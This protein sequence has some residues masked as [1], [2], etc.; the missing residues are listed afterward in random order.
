MSASKRRISTRAFLVAFSLALL[1][2]IVG[3]AAMALVYYASTERARSEAEAA[4]TAR[5]YSTILDG[6]VRTLMSVLNGLAKSSLLRRKE[7]SDFHE[8]ARRTVQGGDEVIVLRRFDTEQILNTGVPFG[9]HLPPAISLIPEEIEAYKSG[10]LRVSNVYASPLG[11][12]PRIAVAMKPEIPGPDD[13]LL[14]ITVPTSRFLQKIRAPGPEPW[15]IGVADRHN[16]YITHSTRHDEVTGKPGVSSYLDGIREAAGFFY[17]NNAAGALL[18]AGYKRSDLT[19]WLT[20]ANIPAAVIEAPLRRSLAIA[21][22]AGVA[23]LLITLALAMYFDHR[24]VGSAQA[25]AA[26]AEALGSG[27]A[28][29]PLS[30]GITEFSVIDAAFVKAAQAVEERRELTDSLAEAVHQKEILLREVNHRVKNSLQ[31][32]ASLLNMQ[33]SQ[34]KDPETRRQFEDAAQRI[35][36]VAKVHQRLYRDERID[37]V[38]L[39]QFLAELCEDLEGLGSGRNIQIKCTAEPCTLPTERIIPVAIIVNELIL[40]A[41]KHSFPDGRIGTIR[42]ECRKEPGSV[43]VSV[44]DDGVEL[45]FD[46]QIGATE[47]GLGMR[48][49]SGLVKQLRATIQ[50]RSMDRGKIFIVQVPIEHPDAS[51]A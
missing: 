26:K 14:A 46:F 40:N 43:T 10:A 39:D 44:F 51:A 8:Q 34:I 49:V 20:T 1:L 7:F 5:E 12:E 2:P 16:V 42:L 48:I 24:L 36:T 27:H 23:I 38:A 50:S 9:E 37:Q 6:D 47:R 3:L 28:L 45:P 35:G 18:L 13:Y 4:Q 11:G 19:G 41:F 22:V 33:R 30:S 31:L 15:L 25:L 17:A 32:V 21:S 29:S